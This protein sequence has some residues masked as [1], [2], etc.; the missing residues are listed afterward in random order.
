MIKK[1]QKNKLIA[2]AKAEMTEN[3][4][5][6]SKSF[7]EH[8]VSMFK[9][10]TRC[11]K[12]AI[13]HIKNMGNAMTAGTDGNCLYLNWN[14]PIQKTFP[15]LKLKIL[16]V[17]GLFYHEIGHML[18]T[19]FDTNTVYTEDIRKQGMLNVKVNPMLKQEKDD[20]EYFL[21]L[22][23]EY[24][25]YLTS[26]Y[27]NI[28]NI[29][30]DIWMEN[31][32]CKEFQGTVKNAITID[33]IKVVDSCKTLK[34]MIAEEYSDTAITLNLVLCYA[35]SGLIPNPHNLITEHTE[36]L[37]LTKPHINAGISND[38]VWGRIIESTNIFLCM[39]QMI[40]SEIEEK[41]EEEKQNS[42]S[43]QQSQISSSVANQL[44][45]KQE[46]ETK[47]SSDSNENATTSEYY[48]GKRAEKEKSEN[49]MDNSKSNQQ[50]TSNG[51]NMDL[52]EKEDGEQSSQNTDETYEDGIEEDY[53]SNGSEENE[54]STEIDNSNESMLPQSLQELH[55]LIQNKLENSPRFAETEGSADGDLDQGGEIEYEDLE[56]STND[57]IGAKI[58]D[59][60]NSYA[61]ETVNAGLLREN[62]NELIEEVKSVPFTN[63]HKGV[64]FK[65]NRHL[66]IS[67]NDIYD[68]NQLKDVLKYSKALQKALEET[69]KRKPTGINRKQWIGKGLDK[70]NLY[71]KQHKV[72]YKKNIPTETN[73]AV[74]ILID[75]SGSMCGRKL[76]EAVRMA[77]ILEDFCRNFNIPLS[78]AGHNWYSC[79]EYDIYKDFDDIDGN[80]KYRLMQITS[81]GCNRDG[82]ALQ[83][84]G[85]HLL[86]RPEEKKLLIIISD[87]QPNA[88][89]YYGEAA[90]ADLKAI[91]KNLKNRGVELFAAAID[92]DK[93]YIKAIYGDG[94][95]DVSD[96][97]R[98]PKTMVRL[99]ECFMDL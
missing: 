33:R 25:E 39:W 2:N 52:G 35:S 1:L 93:E 26:T 46:E 67:E 56:I 29:I 60:I 10:M 21:K 57:G 38:D 24:K 78:I 88:D 59:S 14:N 70:N 64:N 3:D 19:D 41:E 8:L 95:L 81:K 86:K 66:F 7:Y 53:S 15:T 12:K 92:D 75:E 80:D 87:G 23:P 84:C 5:F 65:I 13:I 32:L 16:S 43:Q 63:N 9:F 74:S 97:S 98:L 20:V 77:V 94:F 54:E 76:V 44:S 51:Q 72:F 83:F 91:K 34:R 96:L 79:V 22:K 28:N 61:E 18:Y 47:K 62:E 90:K 31:Q 42:N 58:I 11:E 6:E 82:A 85:E 17:L 71:D 30:E 69:L 55:E 99:I 27:R 48:R 4:Y 50:T 68:Y 73:L 36:V 37:E 45:Q 49:E 89:G 40:K